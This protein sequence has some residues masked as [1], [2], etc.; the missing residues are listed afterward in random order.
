MNR[1]SVLVFFFLGLGFLA[2]Q[3]VNPQTTEDRGLDAMK[4][5]SFLAGRWE[6]EGWMR[7]GPGD[8]QSFRSLELIESRLDGRVL[9]VE[10]IHHGGDPEEIVHHA[11]A[12]ISYDPEAALY[13]FR[14]HLASGES[15]DYQQAQLEDDAFVWGFEVPGRGRVRYTIRVED[16]LWRE[17]GEFSP[18][19][20]RWNQFFE[21]NLRRTGD[22]DRPSS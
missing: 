2:A 11:L 10:G 19:G 8:P 15:G 14:S 5:V 3:D 12:T 16:D 18:D 20:E 6:G 4:A 13:R 21:M 1:Q 22:D 9:I 7:Q 17:V